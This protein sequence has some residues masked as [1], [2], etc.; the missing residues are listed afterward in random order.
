[1]RYDLAANTMV[2]SALTQGKIVVHNPSLWRPFIDVRDVAMAYVR[3]LDADPSL[4]GI[5]N[6]AYDNFTIGRLADEV[7]AAL[8]DHGVRVPIESQ[9]RRDLRNYRV[10]IHKAHQVLDFQAH[11]TMG[12]CVALMLEQIRAG[13]SADLDNPRYTNVEWM[14]QKVAQGWMSWALG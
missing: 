9:R 14:K 1:M 10:A 4:T 5:F 7:V 8:R 2:R 12:Q 11:I 6:I 3:A 13:H